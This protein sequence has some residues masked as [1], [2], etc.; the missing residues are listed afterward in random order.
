MKPRDELLRLLRTPVVWEALRRVNPH[1]L[2]RLFSPGGQVAYT[3]FLR[4]VQQAGLRKLI[5]REARRLGIALCR[6]R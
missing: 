2:A 3:T 4:I 1:L 6:W 5:L